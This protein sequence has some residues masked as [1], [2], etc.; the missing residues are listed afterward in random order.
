MSSEQT[1]E[2]HVHRMPKVSYAR[3]VHVGLVGPKPR[4]TAVGDGQLVYIP[5][6]PAGRYERWG[7]AAGRARRSVGVADVQARRRGGRQIHL[8]LTSR[9]DGES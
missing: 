4:A 5:V 1:C 2:K 3:I 7:D 9:G 8:P 6:P